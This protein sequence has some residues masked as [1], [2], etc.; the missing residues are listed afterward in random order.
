[1]YFHSLVCLTLDLSV[2]PCSDQRLQ[3]PRREQP[4]QQPARAAPGYDELDGQRRRVLEHDPH[5]VSV[6]A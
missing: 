4:Q 2:P 5:R 1:M 3:A 6:H